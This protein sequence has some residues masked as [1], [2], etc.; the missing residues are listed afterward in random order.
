MCIKDWLKPISGAR[1]GVVVK[2][3][4]YKPAGRGFESFR[5]HSGPGLDSAFNRNVSVSFMTIVR[6]IRAK[7]HDMQQSF[8]CNAMGS[9]WVFTL[10]SI[11]TIVL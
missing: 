8:P 10:F 11:M 6:S 1:G 5:S 7:I 4:S 9:H 3:L 2:A